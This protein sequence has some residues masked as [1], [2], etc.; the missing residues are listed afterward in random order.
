MWLIWFKRRGDGSDVVGPKQDTYRTVAT[1]ADRNSAEH[2]VGHRSLAPSGE[3]VRLPE[4]RGGELAGRFVET[5]AGE[6]TCTI[7]PACMT[8]TRTATASASPWS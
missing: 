8:A 2:G 3:E 7:R 5:T 4:E 1:S 6:S